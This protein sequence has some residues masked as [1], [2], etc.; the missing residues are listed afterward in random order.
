MSTH[1]WPLTFFDDDYLKIYQPQ[2]TPELTRSEVD[3]IESALELEKGAAVLDLACGIGRH[4]IGMAQRGYRVTGVDFS[5]RYLEL[6]GQAAARAG[7]EVEWRCSDMRA[8]DFDGRFAAAYS[9]FTSFGYYGDAENEEI[10][11]RITRSLG[12]GGRFLID[13]ANR[14]RML[15]HPQQRGWNPR[16]DGAL[17]MEEVSLDLVTSR[18]TSRQILIPPH[19]GAQVVKTFDLRVYTCA[20]LTA[21]M[22]RH[23]LGVVQVWGGADRSAYSSESRR[24]VMLAE[25]RSANP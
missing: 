5:S 13:M 18:V 14:E 25:R 6:A 2:L 4:A 12:P 3:F 24:L 7:V 15:T 23:G 1:E 22:A 8:L 19:G 20:E 21:L 17:L 10:L 11:G 9:Y 16:P